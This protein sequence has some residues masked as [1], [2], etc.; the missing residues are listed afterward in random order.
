MKDMLTTLKKDIKNNYYDPNYHGIDLDKRFKEASDKLDKATSSNQGLGII[1]Q[2]LLDFNDS[3]LFFKPPPSTLAVE[4]GWRMLAVGDKVY[5][6]K[7]KPGSD[8]D[9]Q[10][11][12]PGDQILS[13]NGFPVSRKE[14]WKINYYYNALSK[15]DKLILSLLSPGQEKPRDVAVKAQLKNLQR[16]ITFTQYY[17]FGEGFGNEEN[18]KE[19]F[20]INNEVT[21]WKMPGFDVDWNLIDGFVGKAKNSATLVLDLRGNS[22]GYVKSM[23]ALVGNVIDHDVMISQELGRKKMDPSKSK[24]KGKSAFQGKLIVLID[25]GS[26]SAS[27]VFARAIQLEK[28]GI[29]LGDVSAGA[30]MTSL[31]FDEEH[32]DDNVVL[33]GASVPIADVIMADGKSLEHVGVTPDELILPTPADMAAGRDPVLARALEIAGAKMSPEDIA[34]VYKYYW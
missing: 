29:V 16:T 19:R 34:K 26:A 8:A 4:Y 10:G 11:V 32:G 6:T 15:R 2:V 25:S 20:A 5:V 12:K 3:H 9:A 24:S 33:Y 14:L 22:G 13:V 1:A 17:R 23:E 27:E 18:D 31:P 7:V 21:L 28:R 30:V